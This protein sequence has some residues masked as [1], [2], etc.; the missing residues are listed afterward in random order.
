MRKRKTETRWAFWST[1]HGPYV[2]ETF[3]TRREARAAKR[4]WFTAFDGYSVRKMRI[5]YEAVS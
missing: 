5:T 4:E 1:V 2:F 3:R